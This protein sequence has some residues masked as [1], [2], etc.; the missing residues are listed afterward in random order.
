MSTE[1]HFNPFPGLR[2]FTQEEDFLFF[3]RE[4]QT[5]ELLELLRAHRFIAVVG[6]SG[7]GKSSLVRAGLLPALF[8]GTMVSVGSRWDVTVFRPG[9]DPIR[10]L[11]ESLVDCDLYDPEDP[12]T[13][14]RVMATLRRSRTGLVEAIRQSDLPEGHNILIVVDQ[15]EELFRFRQTSLDHQDQ[16]TEFV[17]LL[18]NA[19]NA[20]DIPI[21]ITMTMRSDYLGECAQIP[22]LAEAVNSGEYLIPKLTR[23]QRRDAIER[24]VAVGGGSISSRLVNQLLNEVGD[25]VDQLPV[26][27]HALMRVWDAWERD[28][29]ESESLD[30]DHYDQVGGLNHALS[31]HA[32]EVFDSLESDHSKSLC[33]RIFKALT[34]RGDDERGIRR[35]TRMDLLCEIVG[36]THEEVL[37]V[38]DAYRKRGRTFVMPLDE[39]VIEPATVVDISHE[40]LMRVWERLTS[41]VEE[42]SQ[43]A[44]IY[45]RL[46]DTAALFNDNRA[47]HY[48]DPDLQIALSWQEE[49]N[50]TVAWGHRYHDGFPESISF[51][52]ESAAVAHAEEREREAQ[53]LRE[54][55]QARELAAAQKKARERSQ[56][57]TLLSIVAAL[58]VGFLWNDATQQ[59]KE[60]VEARGVAELERDRA[61]DLAKSEATAKEA[62]AQQRAVAESE[63]VRANMALYA[64]SVRQVHTELQANQGKRVAQNLLKRWTDVGTT[65]GAD[66]A[67]SMRDWEWFYLNSQIQQPHASVPV[68]Y[69][70]FGSAIN[71]SIQWSP[72]GSKIALAGT[73]KNLLILDGT[74]YELLQIIPRRQ[75]VF[76]PR[77]CWSP[78]SKQIALLGWW[79][80]ASIYDVETGYCTVEINLITPGST[81]A[82]WH[83]HLNR[84]ALAMNDNKVGIFDTETG[85]LIEA[86][87]TNES[88]V[89]E[90]VWN[91][92]GDLLLWAGLSSI[93]IYEYPTL[94]KLL[95]RDSFSSRGWRHEWFPDKNLVLANYEESS[96]VI[97]DPISNDVEYNPG[98][99]QIG[100]IIRTAI[101]PRKPWAAF[102]SMNGTIIVWDLEAKRELYRFDDLDGI[103][104]E[105]DWHPNED[106]LVATRVNDHIAVYR[107]GDEREPIYQSKA[108]DPVPRSNEFTTTAQWVPGQ[109]LLTVAHETDGK[110]KLLNPLTNLEE[111]TLQTPFNSRITAHAWS[112]S[113]NFLATASKYVIAISKA[114]TPSVPIIELRVR[115]SNEVI[116]QL[117]WSHDDKYVTSSSGYLRF[118]NIVA[119]TPI[120]LWDISEPKNP[121]HISL[122]AHQSQVTSVAW[123]PGKNILASGGMSR[124]NLGSPV[125]LWDLENF[126]GN[127][128]SIVK[129]PVV[130]NFHQVADLKFSPNGQ[131]LAIAYAHRDGV[132]GV[133]AKGVIN[134]VDLENDAVT[135]FAIQPDLI[136]GIDW[137]QSSQRLA[138][139]GFGGRAKVWR[140]DGVEMLSLES[141]LSSLYKIQWSP[142]NRLLL[143]ENIQKDSQT[144][145][146]A[147]SLQTAAIADAPRLI[148]GLIDESNTLPERIAST[149]PRLIAVD[150]EIEQALSLSQEL[151]ERG[152]A[153]PP[154]LVTNLRVQKPISNSKIYASI[155]A[156]SEQDDVAPAGKILTTYV[157]SDSFKS[158]R[159]KNS[160][161]KLWTTL[162]SN[163][164]QVVLPVD[165]TLTQNTHNFVTFSVGSDKPQTAYLTCGATERLFL[166][167]R[168]ATDTNYELLF[169]T[170]IPSAANTAD[171]VIPI[172]L[173]AGSTEILVD[174]YSQTGNPELHM[175]WEWEL[176]SLF[177]DAYA[178]N[179]YSLLNKLLDTPELKT[180]LNDGAR[181]RVLHNLGRYPQALQI[182]EEELIRSPSNS[183]INQ[184]AAKLAYQFGHFKKALSYAQTAYESDPSNT[185]AMLLGKY[186]TFEN[187]VD[188]VPVTSEWQAY[189][190]RHTDYTVE[191]LDSLYKDFSRNDFDTENWESLSKGALLNGVSTTGYATH[192]LGNPNTNASS[193]LIRTTFE[194][195]SDIQQIVLETCRQNGF[196][197]YI[198]GEEVYQYNV[199]AGP[200][201]STLAEDNTAWRFSPAIYAI[202]VSLS[203]GKHTLGISIH[204][205]DVGGQ[206]YLRH[207]RLIGFN[208]D[209]VSNQEDHPPEVLTGNLLWRAIA[210]GES[211]LA[212]NEQT[213][214]LVDDP[215]LLLEKSSNW[216]W[217]YAPILAR[218]DQNLADAMVPF[219]SQIATNNSNRYRRLT[220]FLVEAGRTATLSEILQHW[221]IKYPGDGELQFMAILL[222]YI[223][224]DSGLSKEERHKLIE[225]TLQSTGSRRSEFLVTALCA[226]PLDDYEKQHIEALMSRVTDT[227]IYIDASKY[228]ILPQALLTYRLHSEDSE[229]INKIETLLALQPGQETIAA[230]NQTDHFLLAFY[231]HLRGDPVKAINAYS[232]GVQ[233][234]DLEVSARTTRVG[235]KDYC[236]EI[237]YQRMRK[238][239]GTL[240][241]V[242]N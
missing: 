127:N 9:G 7:S 110:L 86:I 83:P 241:G 21:Y 65:T 82:A 81:P 26:L 47:G 2:P 108:P 235:I 107:I 51:L 200:R 29:R 145:D 149:L 45:K 165:V 140:V 15:F 121:V 43:S 128:T 122:P 12:E 58:F 95:V 73:H 233:Q 80:Q 189:H 209:I 157:N 5:T 135:E 223:D 49:D 204:T 46:A 143:A 17:H 39:F 68:D 202:P 226:Q 62:E 179:N 218:V 239:I 36:G 55:Q 115:E 6:T 186:I 119:P 170:A 124:S 13:I 10:N 30:L 134:I 50:P 34:E 28:Q 232:V 14:P 3:G 93:G 210:K 52:E 32:D 64:T 180:W 99:L 198:D 91:H 101:H 44:R 237:L 183:T 147:D 171:Y 161:D 72:D 176:D 125:I 37:N 178:A 196:V 19:A 16:A 160:T 118:G 205:R 88:A 228:R 98:D 163:S 187:A 194:V 84:L 203:R 159:R 240:V 85:D 207:T 217:E 74:T 33:E 181:S 142:D 173:E 167:R 151:R 106:T 20:S 220:D 105:L 144:W 79:S 132:F 77:M 201:F 76:N 229:T 191:E 75:T 69:L 238:E 139:A 109:T 192:P 146:I 113:G 126:D 27:Q 156:V 42:E 141:R 116:L 175:S 138:T 197:L 221:L 129:R 133:D 224:L 166:W 4:D 114:D 222:A 40:S 97:W 89:N 87:R 185:N 216:L 155:Q 71:S 123:H 213:L 130:S 103:G 150:G 168:T 236:L 177:V 24:P 172:E 56:I 219:F 41:W 117:A 70:R 242:E 112:P 188:V 90:I 61:N 131:N 23:D 38:L 199:A 92:K 25:E 59:R 78:D 96:F 195:E 1:S 231:H 120:E 182:L 66:D 8:G 31:Q 211:D 227:D 169:S 164:R 162:R 190:P 230:I 184:V 100:R 234:H 225:N 214:S 206:S 153:T 11:A 54:L 22:G 35:P 174:V 148:S 63:T 158:Q 137:S 152:V 212:H 60:A 104:L 53:R 154:Y 48:R 215:F 18:L 193:A 57:I 67:P 111:G 136:Y 94:E 208:A 102:S